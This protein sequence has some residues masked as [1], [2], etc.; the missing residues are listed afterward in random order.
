MRNLI[1][2]FPPFLTLNELIS[3]YQFDMANVLEHE[4][5]LLHQIC[6]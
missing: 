1:M 5:L 4:T 2:S 6:H 3:V